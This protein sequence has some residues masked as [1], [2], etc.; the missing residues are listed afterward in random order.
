MALLSKSVQ[1]L[2]LQ[3]LLNSLRD[4]W[5]FLE[6]CA[7]VVWQVRL[8]VLLDLRRMLDYLILGA[9]GSSVFAF[10]NQRGSRI[11]SLLLVWKGIV[12]WNLMRS[13]S[14]LLWRLGLLRK[15]THEIDYLDLVASNSRPARCWG[16]VKNVTQF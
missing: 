2:G 9:F 15:V 3:C 1:I 8:K 14:I 16:H 12:T 10:S 5:R 13:R 6:A 7:L 4:R 11:L